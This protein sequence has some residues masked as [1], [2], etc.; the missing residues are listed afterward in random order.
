[1]RCYCTDVLLHV[2]NMGGYSPTSHT[3]VCLRYRHVISVITFTSHRL[4][5]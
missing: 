4:D 3:V 1:M 5:P 2:V